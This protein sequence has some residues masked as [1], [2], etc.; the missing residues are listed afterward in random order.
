MSRRRFSVSILGAPSYP[1]SLVR[2]GAPRGLHV[3]KPSLGQVGDKPRL[4]NIHGAISE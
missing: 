1:N 2:V 3:V 4:V